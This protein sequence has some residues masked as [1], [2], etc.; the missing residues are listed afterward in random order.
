MTLSDLPQALVISDAGVQDANGIYK[1]T[2]REYC[3]APV[4]EHVERGQDLK[5]TREPHK[6]PKT[7]AIKHGW[8]LGQGGRPL[9]GAP[10]ESLAV[11]ASGWKKH[12]ICGHASLCLGVVAKATHGY[13]HAACKVNRQLAAVNAAITA[14]ARSRRWQEG[15]DLARQIL[16]SSL[17]PS[18]ISLTASISSLEKG[19]LWNAACAT[20][21][22][23]WA[24]GVQLDVVAFMASMAACEKARCWNWS[25]WLLPK[26]RSAS[27][28]PD[29]FLYNGAIS[30]CE[31]SAKWIGALRVLR[32]V[33][34]KLQSDLVSHTACVS[35]CEKGGQWTKSVGLLWSMPHLGLQPNTI[36]F[37]AGLS[38]CE[39][40]G[41]WRQVCG[42]LSAASRIDM[43]LDVAFSGLLWSM[44]HS[45][46][47]WNVTPPLSPTQPEASAASPAS[48][49][50]T[51]MDASSSPASTV[52]GLSSP[53][54]KRKRVADD[55]EG[56]VDPE[57]GRPGTAPLQC[58]QGFLDPE[59]GRPGLATL[60]CTQGFSTPPRRERSAMEFSPEAPSGSSGELRRGLQ[61][62]LQ[63]EQMA[64]EDPYFEMDAAQEIP[65]ESIGV[66]VGYSMAEVSEQVRCTFWLMYCISLLTFGQEE[67]ESRQQTMTNVGLGFVARRL[68]SGI[69]A[70][71]DCFR[72]T[73]KRPRLRHQCVRATT[74]CCKELKMPTEIELGIV[75]LL[76]YST[77]CKVGKSSLDCADG[78]DQPHAVARLHRYKKSLPAGSLQ[79]VPVLYVC[80]SG[81]H[82]LHLETYV[83]GVMSVYHPESKVAAPSTENAAD[84]KECY[85]RDS[86][87]GLLEVLHRA[88]RKTVAQLSAGKNAL[89]TIKKR[90]S[91]ENIPT[92]EDFNSSHFHLSSN[93]FHASALYSRCEQFGYEKDVV[94]STAAT[95]AFARGWR[96]ERAVACFGQLP[97][98]GIRTDRGLVNSCL[99]ALDWGQQWLASM[100]TAQQWL[101]RMDA[102]SI[103]SLMSAGNKCQRWQISTNL[104]H[105]TKS[106]EVA[107]DTVVLDAA[108]SAQAV[109][110]RWRG[111]TALL[112]QA[113]SAGLE[114]MLATG[115]ALLASYSKAS[116]PLVLQLL[117]LQKEM[118][119]DVIAYNSAL[120]SMVRWK[121]GLVLLRDMAA[122]RSL[123]TSSYGL[124]VDLCIRG[125]QVAALFGGEEPI[126]TVQVHLNMDEVLFKSADDRKAEGEHALE[127]EDW[128]GAIRHF[129]D[130]IDTM[131]RANDCLSDGFKS[132]ASLLLC[133]RGSAHMRMQE[134]KAALRD[135]VAAMDLERQE[136]EKPAHGDNLWFPMW[137]Q[138]P[139]ARH[140]LAVLGFWV[141]IAGHR[142]AP[143]Q[144]TGLG[145]ERCRLEA[146]RLSAGPSIEKSN[147]QLQELGVNL[148]DLEESFSRSAGPG[149]Q[150]VNKVETAVR[151]RHAPTGLEVKAQ[152]H[153]TQLEN[154]VS[155]RRRLAEL[156]KKTVLGVE[157]KADRKA[158]K[159][160]SNKARRARRRRKKAEAALA[161]GG[162][163]ADCAEGNEG[164]ESPT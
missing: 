15:V 149:G 18:L 45:S 63:E 85:T 88:S 150:N 48:A 119:L 56:V 82:A 110:R 127:K 134:P 10:T 104:Y 33:S 92:K 131:K 126:P 64:T 71:F 38:A 124:L 49:A 6:N 100:Q 65:V 159:V 97:L 69:Q 135:A 113:R 46:M 143:V 70:S 73:G 118:T 161:Q 122:S 8:L 59:A 12:C 129:T 83:H 158:Q 130:G 25:F 34:E 154:R 137:R 114:A 72:A 157:T 27:L 160:R 101:G 105:S 125:G 139:R 109:N 13:M 20:L 74:L 148:K 151:L 37:N 94:S 116:W 68:L 80:P 26:M 93:P 163:D 141:L 107:A 91:L 98:Q 115:N 24:T 21:A 7:G 108:I 76:V 4:Y 146:T 84:G 95:N 87:Q 121:Q 156:Y 42:L 96:W 51:V 145:R 60:E 75:H 17:Q 66:Q 136:A 39:K 28:C 89:K 132:R 32:E 140:S 133:R 117:C 55:T 128:Q 23:A 41:L 1:A 144:F 86:A 152:T 58:T 31:K 54:L 47:F 81:A 142:Y 53:L 5:I 123:D 164:N 11:P 14:A 155:A 35:A 111:A 102:V 16:P 61:S 112:S 40:S 103:G 120:G 67:H 62:L 78:P 99:N 90:G 43:A 106:M 50:A 44:S 138:V 36:S 19:L 52:P 30:A 147:Q 162:A 79:Y 153:R 29:A 22:G 3:D 57:A 2:G 77:F 9:Y